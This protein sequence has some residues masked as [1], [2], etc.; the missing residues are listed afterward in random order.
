MWNKT[1][2]NAIDRGFKNIITLR[3]FAK[4]SLA[5]PV[6]QKNDNKSSFEGSSVRRKL[7][8]IDIM[9]AHLSYSEFDAEAKEDE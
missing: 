4:L 7:E 6:E 8:K 5:A 3:P 9:S 2:R 1:F